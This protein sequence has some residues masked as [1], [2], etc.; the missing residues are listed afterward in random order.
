MTNSKGGGSQAKHPHGVLGPNKD[1]E[2][3]RWLQVRYLLIW[4]LAV[5]GDWLQGPYVYKVYH[6]H[7]YDRIEIQS[8]FVTGCL[9]A[10]I[11]G[12]PAAG[13]ADFVGRKKVVMAYFMTYAAS[14]FTYHFQNMWIL[15]LGRILSGISQSLHSSDDLF[16][17]SVFESWL[18]RRHN[19]EGFPSEWIRDTFKKAS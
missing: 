14:C 11:L 18:V 17:Y 13:L 4:A 3:F 16:R 2:A 6:R 1:I 15:V 5:F 12:A 8:L 7:G 9:S 19:T 10:A